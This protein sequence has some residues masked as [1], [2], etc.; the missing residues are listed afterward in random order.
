M[1]RPEEATQQQPC[2]SKKM[3]VV[4][5]NGVDEVDADADADA[6]VEHARSTGG[7]RLNPDQCLSKPKRYNNRRSDVPNK[8]TRWR[9]C[10]PSSDAR[11]TRV[12][13][14]RGRKRQRRSTRWRWTDP[15]D[16]NDT[17]D[18]AASMAAQGRGVWPALAATMAARD[19]VRSICLHAMKIRC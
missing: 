16:N 4:L 19:G 13:N 11:R 2:C 5:G 3:R 15:P 17:P 12:T 18:L 1:L 9:R 10:V 7:G 8:T 6:E 14:M